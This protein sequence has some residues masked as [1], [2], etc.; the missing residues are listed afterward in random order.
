M[1]KCSVR[2]VALFIVAVLCPPLAVM[3]VRDEL[4]SYFLLNV[5]L[6]LL[7]WLPGLIHAVWVLLNRNPSAENVWGYEPLTR[8][9]GMV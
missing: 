6:T 1:A 2:S 3:L 7:G 4:D 8:P 5:L 9:G